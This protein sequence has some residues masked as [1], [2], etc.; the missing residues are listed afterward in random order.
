[1]RKLIEFALNNMPKENSK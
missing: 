1:V